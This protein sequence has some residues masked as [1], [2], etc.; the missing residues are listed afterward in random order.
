MSK[1]EK[2]TSTSKR[3]AKN[4]EKWARKEVE[5]KSPSR[6]RSDLQTLEF[7]ALSRYN[8][9]ELSGEDASKHWNVG[10]AG[11]PVVIQF[12]LS[13]TVQIAKELRDQPK[14]AKR[15]HRATGNPV[16][17]PANPFGR[18]PRTDEKMVKEAKVKLADS[19]T[20]EIT[21]KKD[22]ARLCLHF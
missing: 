11:K 8:S 15:A 12:H 2:S 7:G 17:R 13:L 14:F 18:S 3:K 16:G 6:L 10:K 21:L 20:S 9:S 1:R 19:T 4:K 5:V 22:V